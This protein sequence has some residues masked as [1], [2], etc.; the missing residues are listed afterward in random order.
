M[1]MFES[2]MQTARYGSPEQITA[3]QALLD[4]TTQEA[5]AILATKDTTTKL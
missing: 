2:V 1:A 3:L 5:R 4:R